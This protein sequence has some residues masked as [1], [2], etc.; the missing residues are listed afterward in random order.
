ML[1][2]NVPTN[3]DL[4]N[5]SKKLWITETLRIF[6]KDVIMFLL[7]RVAVCDIKTLDLLCQQLYFDQFKLLIAGG[8][9]TTLILANTFITYDNNEG[10]PL[11]FVFKCLP[12]L[13]TLKM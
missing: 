12:T 5:L 10:I 7:R 13:V 3:I 6:S 9:I 1:Q 2:S 8:K 11:E 4:M